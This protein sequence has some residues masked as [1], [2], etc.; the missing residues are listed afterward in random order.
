MKE[1]DTIDLIE[2]D[3]VKGELK[4]RVLIHKLLD[5]NENTGRYNVILVSWKGGINPSL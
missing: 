2:N 3:D 4:K 5:Q 1:S